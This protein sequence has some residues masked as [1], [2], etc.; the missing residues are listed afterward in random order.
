MYLF[1]GFTDT[2]ANLNSLYKLDL[3]TSVWSRADGLPHSE[4]YSDADT[5][6][7]GLHF[8]KKKRW[9]IL[10]GLFRET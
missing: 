4:D 8:Q 3:K 10:G 1:A 2:H 7:E 9:E 5:D 6:D